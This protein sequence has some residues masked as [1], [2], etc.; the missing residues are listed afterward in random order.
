MAGLDDLID[1]IKNNPPKLWSMSDWETNLT[2]SISN[3]RDIITDAYEDP[4]KWKLIENIRP[5]R[6][7][8]DLCRILVSSVGLELAKMWFYSDVDDQKDAVKHGWRRSWLDENIH[9]WSEFDSNMK[10]NVLTGTFDRSPGEPFES[11]EDWKREFRSLTKGSINWEKFLIPYTGYIPSP[12]IEKLRNIIERARDMEYLAKIDEMI[13]LREI[14]CRNIVSQMQMSQMQPRTRCNPN[15][16]ERELIARL[17]EITGRNG[18]S[19]VALPPIFL[20]SETPPIFVAHP[21]LEEDED[22]PLGDRNEQGI[23][24]NQQ[25]R[26]PETISIE[27]LLGV[28]QPQHEQIIIYERGI[29]WRRH[30]LDEEWLFAVVLVHEIAHWITHILPKP[31][32]PTWKTDLYVLGETDVHE[33]WAQL[34]TYWIANQVGG[35]FK[36]TFEKLNRNQPPPYRVFE[37]FKNEPINK[38]M[39]SL[40][41]LRSLPSRVQLQDW[42][43]AIDQS[44]F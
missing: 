44:T 19:P 30:R 5:K 26:Q 12:Q 32:T 24:R 1:F 18:Y 34:M 8:D 9:L 39:V 15:R 22:T 25:R 16:N 14:A 4:R 7:Y 13:S 6:D 27:E 17:M 37:E 10:D 28:Y 38:V 40:E 31:G 11:F 21:E 33:G 29:R 42:K 35:E 3:W 23:P 43:E 41:T 36:R 20:S 2:R